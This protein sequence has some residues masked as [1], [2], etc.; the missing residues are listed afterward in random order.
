MMACR[1]GRIDMDQAREA[2]EA[3]RERNEQ[4]IARAKFTEWT[5]SREP[6]GDVRRLLSALGEALDAHPV[7]VAADG[8]EHCPRCAWSI[9]ERVPLDQC[10]LRQAILTGLLAEAERFHAAIDA[11]LANG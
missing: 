6:P 4:Y 3:V 10:H 2:L 9:G 8:E 7:S 11:E 5:V 1:S